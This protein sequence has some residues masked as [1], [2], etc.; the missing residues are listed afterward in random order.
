[1]PLA[2]PP[3]RNPAQ[4][5]GLSQLISGQQDNNRNCLPSPATSP[6]DPQIDESDLWIVK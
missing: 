1:M 5:P 6:L 2:A 3:R 4:L